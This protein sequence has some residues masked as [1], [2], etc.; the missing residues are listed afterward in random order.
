M[1]VTGVDLTPEFCAAA[2][3]LNLATGLDGRVTIKNGS[4]LALPVPDSAFDRAYSQNV[5]MN[6]ADKR[7]FYREAFRALKPGGL[8]ALSNLCAGNGEELIYPVPWAD[9]AATSFLATPQEMEADLRAAGFVI[10]AFRN[11]T[12]DVEEATRRNRERLERD[13]LG[14][15]GTHLILGDGLRQMQI[16]SS[17]NLEQ[18][19]VATIEALVQK[20]R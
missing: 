9:T 16:N 8:L 18:G 5:I 13:G 1:Q 19:K 15:L 10:V 20:P 14:P 3:A 4:A 7:Q 2:E 17:L 11:T 6:I 12:A